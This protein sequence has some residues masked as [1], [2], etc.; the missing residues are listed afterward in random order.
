M[1]IPQYRV[2]WGKVEENFSLSKRYG[3]LKNYPFKW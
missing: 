3:G 2:V 1:G